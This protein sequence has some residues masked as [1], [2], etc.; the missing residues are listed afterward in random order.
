MIVRFVNRTGAFALRRLYA[1][2]ALMG[3]LYDTLCGLLQLRGKRHISSRQLIDQV[4]FTGVDAFGIVGLVALLAGV[5]ISVQA[6]TNM[7]KLGVDDYF[8]SLMVIAV[9]RE[10]GP[11]FTSLV[12]IGRSGAA[13]AAYIGNMKVNKEIAALEASGIDLVHYLVVPAFAGMIVSLV[14]LT[15]YFDIIA[16]G[17]GLLLAS[18]AAL[19]PFAGAMFKV[20]E[21]MSAKDIMISLTKNILFGGTIALI[22]CFQGLQVDNVRIVPRAVFRA[23]VGSM[24]ITMVLNV[25]LTVVFYA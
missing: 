2:F 11:F 6:M 21:A 23:V 20:V 12:V 13:L 14:C 1:A 17:G 4:L 15:I 5:T 19:T 7:P 16:I 3:L 8:G 24:I 10:L 25:L 18:G 9:I 22:S